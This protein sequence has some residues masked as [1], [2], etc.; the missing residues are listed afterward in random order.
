MAT[1]Y[2]RKGQQC[3][4]C[5]AFVKGIFTPQNGK[6]PAT[7]EYQRHK[8]LGKRSWCRYGETPRALGGWPQWALDLWPGDQ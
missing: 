1:R 4:G 3:P 7:F 5:S 8:A 6:K 2:V